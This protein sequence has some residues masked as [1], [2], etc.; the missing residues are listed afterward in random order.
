MTQPMMIPRIGLGCFERD[1]PRDVGLHVRDVLARDSVF[2][3]LCSCGWLGTPSLHDADA[4]AER[5]EVESLLIQ[6][7]ERARRILHK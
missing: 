7:A 6:S 1:L 5:C 4:R 3:P 2:Y